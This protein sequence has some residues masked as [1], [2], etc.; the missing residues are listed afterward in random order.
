MAYCIAYSSVSTEPDPAGLL[1]LNLK[2]DCGS[3][4]VNP[5]ANY[6][7]LAVGFCKKLYEFVASVLPIQMSAADHSGAPQKEQWI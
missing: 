7:L 2:L 1:S 4:L 5:A 3:Q 6:R